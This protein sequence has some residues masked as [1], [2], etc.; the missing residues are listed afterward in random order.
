FN[1][2]LDWAHKLLG[3]IISRG[4]HK[5]LVFRVALR[6]NE[7][8]IDTDLL[9]HL[10]AAGV[11]F[12]MFGVENGNQAMLDHM[13]KGITIEEVKRAFRVAQDAGLKT[14]AFF[15]VGMPGETHQT[16]QDSLNLYK[17]IKPYWGGFSM[18]MP[19]PGTGLTEELRKS[20]NLLC[21]D[22]DKFGPECKAVKTD[23]LSADEIANYVK[24]LNGMARQDKIMHPK[25]L[26]YAIKGKV[27][28]R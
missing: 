12:V 9:S 13:K 3:L 10:R 7:K 15:I 25:Q 18:A 6:V 27:F 19:F 11:W 8:I 14:E 26:M 23:T 16:V 4:Y 24:L 21:E 17:A 28:G 22:Y 2:N 5:K 1:A 20:G